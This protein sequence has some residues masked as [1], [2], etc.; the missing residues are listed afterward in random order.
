MTQ[1]QISIVANILTVDLKCDRYRENKDEIVASW[2]DETIYRPSFDEL[3]KLR[4]I[5]LDGGG[6]IDIEYDDK[7]GS[8]VITVIKDAAAAR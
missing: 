5:V 3:D 1:Q 2:E 4:T 6:E 8:Y 7:Y